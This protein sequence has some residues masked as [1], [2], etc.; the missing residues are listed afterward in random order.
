MSLL[1]AWISRD[2]RRPSAV[3]IAADSRIT[4]G[5]EKWDRGKKVFTCK[6]QPW[7]FGFCGSVLVPTQV[8]A[9]LTDAIDSGLITN[10][11]RDSATNWESIRLYLQKALTGS[12]AF[13]AKSNSYIF[14]FHRPTDTAFDAG[15]Y[16]IEKTAVHFTHVT[17]D[18]N[19]SAIIKVLGSGKDCFEEIEK[20]T[21]SRNSSINV[22]RICFASFCRAI[23]SGKVHSV[24][25]APQLVSL[26]RTGVGYLIPIL[27]EKVMYHQGV[28]TDVKAYNGECFDETLQRIDPKMGCM[29][30]GAQRQPLR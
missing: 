29:P 18:S 12:G 5:G 6:T 8:I 22:A 27:F 3:Y 7:I 14:G 2:Q 23:Q 24:G 25:G 17:N 16:T 28:E 4:A 21:L 15:Y 1:V 26:R 30:D 11:D 10:P 19:E 20:E 13:L 9:E